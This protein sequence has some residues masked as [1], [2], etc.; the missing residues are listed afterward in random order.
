MAVKGSCTET[1]GK[2][3]PASAFSSSPAPVHSSRSLCL[4]RCSVSLA[5]CSVA[6]LSR[7]LRIVC[8]RSLDRVRVVGKWCARGVGRC[9]GGFRY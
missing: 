9:S 5:R 7:R 2:P 1:S 4:L 8:E 3:L 6:V